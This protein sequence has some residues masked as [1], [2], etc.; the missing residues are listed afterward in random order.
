MAKIPWIF[1]YFGYNS[2]NFPVCSKF[3]NWKMH[4]H[5]P[6]FSRNHESKRKC[7]YLLHRV[8]LNLTRD[9]HHL[10]QPANWWQNQLI[11]RFPSG[12]KM[13]PITTGKG[14]TICMANQCLQKYVMCCGICTFIMGTTKT[15]T[16][17]LHSY[18]VFNWD[19]YTRAAILS[20]LQLR[21]LP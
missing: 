10:L 2:L 5:F 20:W 19:G 11:S 17:K 15:A 21:L 8:T 18:H 7:I 6:R 9:L 4:S 3:L 1:Q 14:K 13:V 12:F 16:L